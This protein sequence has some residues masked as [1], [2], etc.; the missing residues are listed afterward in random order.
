MGGCLRTA[1]DRKTL[2][3]EQAP[4]QEIIVYSAEKHVSAA[5]NPAFQVPAAKGNSVAAVNSLMYASAMLK[6]KRPGSLHVFPERSPA[7]ALRN[8]PGSTS[9]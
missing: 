9:Q 2:L 3:G 8:N 1:Y 4:E 7:I 6:Y 5:I